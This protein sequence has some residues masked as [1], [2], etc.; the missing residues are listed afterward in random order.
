MKIGLHSGIKNKSIKTKQQS[1][2]PLGVSFN[3]AET[4]K[5]KSSVG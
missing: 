4:G 1:R 5:G 2:K 3:I